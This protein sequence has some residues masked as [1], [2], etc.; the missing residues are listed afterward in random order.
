M[1]VFQVLIRIFKHIVRLFFMAIERMNRFSGMVDQ[2]TPDLIPENVLSFME[3]VEVRDGTARTRRGS[4][5]HR[6]K[7]SGEEFQGTGIFK[8]SFDSASQQII[9]IAQSKE[10]SG[11]ITS[12][13]DATGGIVQINSVNSLVQGDIVTISGTVDYDGSFTVRVVTST[14]FRIVATFTSTKTG[15]WETTGHIY[16]YQFPFTPFR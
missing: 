2:V 7:I 16:H 4:H 6:E 3:N 10:L 11:V 15:N 13:T 14:S 8:D 9:L 12:V 1:S 5:L